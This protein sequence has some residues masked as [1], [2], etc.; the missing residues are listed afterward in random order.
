MKTYTEIDQYI[1]QVSQ[2]LAKLSR[3]LVPEKDDDSHTNLYW[4]PIHQRLLG[5]WIST[6]NGKVMPALYL[7]RMSFQ[8]LDQ[9]MEVIQEISLLN[10]NHLEAE[11]LVEKSA[12]AIGIQK[13]NLMS[14]LHFDIPDYPFVMHPIQTIVENTLTEWSHFRS[15]ANHVL[16][17]IGQSVQKEV[18]TR[19]WPHHFDTG[20]FF[21]W[22]DTLGIGAGLAMEDKMAGA[23]YFYI[24]G[25]TGDHQIDYAKAAKL[26]RGKWIKDGSWK[27][28][29]LPIDQ[30]GTGIDV[31]VLHDFY[32]HSLDFLLER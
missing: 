21:Q 15:L 24:S 31:E 25:Y 4:E 3:S 32:R 9:Q 5:R 7:G 12:Y 2:I 18:D 14:P 1:H 27:G 19:I 11:T 10:K 8:W 17:D 28:G 30:M 29:I 23:P 26:S 6:S 16:R 22:N 20:I 13:P